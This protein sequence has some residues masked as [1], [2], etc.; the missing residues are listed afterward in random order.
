M[1]S[2]RGMHKKPISQQ[3]LEIAPEYTDRRIAEMLA[4]KCLTLTEKPFQFS[5]NHD[6]RPLKNLACPIHFDWAR[7]D[8]DGSETDD[9]EKIRRW[10]VT[11]FRLGYTVRQMHTNRTL[12]VGFPHSIAI[13]RR[14]AALHQAPKVDNDED[15]PF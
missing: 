15:I 4:A 6:L 11:A 10:L 14:R 1:S 3:L 2:L 5:I 12:A 7:K 13:A 9:K 8:H